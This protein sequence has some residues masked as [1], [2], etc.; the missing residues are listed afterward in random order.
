LSSC[1]QHLAGTTKAAGV[2]DV[3]QQGNIDSYQMAAD[4]VQLASADLGVLRARLI[5]YGANY[6]SMGLR[7][8]Q[9]DR[10]GMVEQGLAV[11]PEAFDEGG[12]KTV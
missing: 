7:F 11:Y 3:L 6:S 2:V 8:S 4:K 10:L 5:P 9:L 12:K 1:K